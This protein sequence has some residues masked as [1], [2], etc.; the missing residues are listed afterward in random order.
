MARLNERNCVREERD[1]LEMREE[2]GR[3]GERLGGYERGAGQ[4]RKEIA[5]L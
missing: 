4:E 3:R 2:L 1:G 5:R